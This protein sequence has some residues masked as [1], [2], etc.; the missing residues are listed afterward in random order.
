MNVAPSRATKTFEENRMAILTR[1]D[2]G[3]REGGAD[4]ALLILRLVLGV[5]ILLHGISKL[6]PPPTVI[7]DILAK[8]NLPAVLAYGSYIGEIVAPILLIIGIWTRLAALV[9]V[10]NMIFA[11][12]L[13]HTGQLFSLGRTGGYALELQAM[14]LFTA[15]ALALTGAGRFSVGGRYGPL[16]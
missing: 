3:K 6:P 14:Y 5:L 1:R 9:I 4:A 11:V 12:L 13:A 2:A 7:V 16:N 15:V 10:I 8:A